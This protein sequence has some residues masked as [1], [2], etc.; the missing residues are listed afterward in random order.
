V[1]YPIV[2][3]KLQIM[4][5]WQRARVCLC[6]RARACVCVCVHVCVCVCVCVYTCVC[7]CVCV[8]DS[9]SDSDSDRMQ[10][11]QKLLHCANTLA[12]AEQQQI[13]PLGDR[14]PVG[15]DS[16][17]IDLSCLRIMCFQLTLS[18][19]PHPS[20]H[21]PSA[22][23]SMRVSAEVSAPIRSLAVSRA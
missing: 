21:L 10:R 20:S 19:V 11:V 8:C 5:A 1:L 16:S 4:S 18:W 14:A 9:D 15:T 13:V 7:V 3:I 2:S 17:L 6:V 12:P 22:E 23:S